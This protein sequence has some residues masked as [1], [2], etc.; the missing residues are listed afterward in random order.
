MNYLSTIAWHGL[1]VF[2]FRHRGEG[3]EKAT[4]GNALAIAVINTLITAL[5][6]VV[7]GTDLQG[8][9]LSLIIY[10]GFLYLFFKFWTE[11]QL[12]GIFCLFFV[13]A[14][15]RIVNATLFSTWIG[16]DNMVFIMWESIA[17]IVFITRVR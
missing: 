8:F 10:V 11:Q 3:L 13:F 14:C 1:N 6:L 12:T 7:E 9:L 15:L 17:M 5:A 2:M 16:P 4:K